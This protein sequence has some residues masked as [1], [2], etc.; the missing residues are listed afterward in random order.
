MAGLVQCVWGVARGEILDELLQVLSELA[1]YVGTL[2]G[3][4]PTR[5]RVASDLARGLVRW[6]VSGSD[7]LCRQCFSVSG[8]AAP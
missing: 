7:M 5:V 1:P 2:R 3:T 6:L 4:T 8:Y